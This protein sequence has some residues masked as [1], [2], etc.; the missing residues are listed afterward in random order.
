MN[1]DTAESDQNKNT[2]DVFDSNNVTEKWREIHL[3]NKIINQE[4]M[5][6]ILFAICKSVW[7]KL[8]WLWSVHDEN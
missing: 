4:K 3:F 5:L 1:A 8:I 7:F 6:L 2:I